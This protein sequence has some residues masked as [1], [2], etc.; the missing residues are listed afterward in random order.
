MIRLSWLLRDGWPVRPNA[1]GLTVDHLDYARSCPGSHFMGASRRSNQGAFDTLKVDDVWMFLWLRS[2]GF[3]P[4]SIRIGAF[5]ELSY[6]VHVLTRFLYVLSKFRSPAAYLR[7]MVCS[8]IEC[9][10]CA[11]RSATL[12]IAVSTS[13]R[14]RKYKT[15]LYPWLRQREM[16]CSYECPAKVVSKAKLTPRRAKSSIRF[17]MILPA[18]IA[19]SSG[20]NGDRPAAIRSAFTKRGQPASF[21]RYSVAKVVF[22]AP[23][24][25]AMISIWL[26]SICLCSA[27]IVPPTWA[28]SSD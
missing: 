27:F 22:P 11:T 25:P 7:R 26:A 21:G 6:T 12:R 2:H 1:R 15:T 23:F 20:P 19:A 3:C 13:G 24:G 28:H 17:N 10:P 4:Q 9:P 16:R 18:V 8:G 5:P 14:L